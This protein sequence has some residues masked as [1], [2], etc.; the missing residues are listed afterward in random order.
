M[1]S[2][3]FTIKKRE[4]SAEVRACFDNPFTPSC[5]PPWP[6]C[7]PDACKPAPAVGALGF[8][9]RRLHHIIIINSEFY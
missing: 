4:L 3:S 5:G 8:D 6:P 9:S 7:G 1:G 2:I